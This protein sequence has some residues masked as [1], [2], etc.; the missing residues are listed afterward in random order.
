[1]GDILGVSAGVGSVVGL[2]FDLEVFLAFS[3]SLSLS[4]L[5]L[6]SDEELSDDESDEELS[7]DESD[8][9][10]SEE[11]EPSDSEEELESEDDE[12]EQL[13]SNVFLSP[14]TV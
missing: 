12:S 1:M 13:D 8:E 10:V 2:A 14:L 7:D 11:D 6:E 5:L 9:E 4:E 3:S